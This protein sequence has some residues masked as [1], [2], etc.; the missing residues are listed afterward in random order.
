M[1][2]LNNKRSDI[3]YNFWQFS[4]FNV[5]SFLAIKS[6]SFKRHQL[7]DETRSIWFYKLFFTF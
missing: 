7:S 5:D 1:M 4:P 6:I 2:Q 3:S